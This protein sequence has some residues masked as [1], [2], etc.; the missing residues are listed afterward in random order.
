MRFEE[1]RGKVVYL[2]HMSEYLVK[3]AKE[4]LFC[5]PQGLS[6]VRFAK[7]IYFVH[8]SLVQKKFEDASSLKFIRMPLGPVPLG[9]RDLVNVADFEVSEEESNLSYNKFIYRL[10]GN[11]I[12]S[13]SKRS[14]EINKVVLQLRHFPTSWLVGVS[15]KEPSWINLKN[16]DEYFISQ[17]DLKIPLPHGKGMSLSHEFD[18]QKMQAKLVEGMIDDIVEESTSLEYPQVN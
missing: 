4:V 3:L 8:K 5:E 10:R 18:E 11:F 12:S 9:F 1:W 17:E 2:F 15:H 7:F 16:G 14:D 13:S 6:R